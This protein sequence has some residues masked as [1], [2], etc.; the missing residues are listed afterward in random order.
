M[1]AIVFD[2]DRL[3]HEPVA[4]RLLL[5]GGEQADIADMLLPETCTALY[6]MVSMLVAT[7]FDM[8]EW[9]SRLSLRLGRS[10]VKCLW[11]VGQATSL[12]VP[13]FS[14]GRQDCDDS[15]PSRTVLAQFTPG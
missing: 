12:F 1:P 14:K 9:C 3:C 10:F 11:L 2:S 7:L 13:A 5:T 15:P 6:L 4:P 8:C